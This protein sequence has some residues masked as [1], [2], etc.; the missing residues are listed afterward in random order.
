[1]MAEVLIGLGIAIVVVY[2]L[3]AVLCWIVQGMMD[4]GEL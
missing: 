1:M 2:V 4:R 3:F